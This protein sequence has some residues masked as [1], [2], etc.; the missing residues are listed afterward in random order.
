MAKNLNPTTALQEHEKASLT[1]PESPHC[2]VQIGDGIG[3]GRGS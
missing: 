3:I 2:T 1:V